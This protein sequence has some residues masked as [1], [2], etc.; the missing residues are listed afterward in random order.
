MAI[1]NFLK[2]LNVVGLPAAVAVGPPGGAPAATN[3]LAG[4][5]V[6]TQQQSEWC[7]AAV[8][9]SVAVFYGST[10]WTQCLVATAELHPLD[11]CGADASTGCNQPWSL[12][13][14]LSAVG[15]FDR[16]VWSSV[17]FA[18]VTNEINAG[19]PLG[20]RIQWTGGGAHFVALGGWSTTVD[21][22]EYVDVFDPY[23][24]YVQKVYNDFV[25]AYKAPGDQWTHSYFTTAA[26]TVAG[27]GP[28]RVMASPISA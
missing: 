5:S 16:L 21:G 24:G 19:R 11:C 8:S 1:A 26:Q 9:T 17:L 12:D 10:Q 2:P 28:A 13:T 18:D 3:T 25:S 7:W 23:Y 6:Q 14:A 22:T 20:C 15:H 27:G 4:F